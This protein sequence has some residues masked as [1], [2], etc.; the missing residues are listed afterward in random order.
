MPPVF[1]GYFD[2]LNKLNKIGKEY[3]V[4]W[5]YPNH[6]DIWWFYQWINGVFSCGLCSCFA[7]DFSTSSPSSSYAS[8][9]FPCLYPCPCCLSFFS[10]DPYPS[11]CSSFWSC[12]RFLN[13]LPSLFSSSFLRFR[14]SFRIQRNRQ[15]HLMISFAISSHFC[16][17]YSGLTP[18]LVVSAL[19]FLSTFPSLFL[20]ISLFLSPD[21]F[22]FPWNFLSNHLCRVS[23]HLG[24]DHGLYPY[25]FPDPDWTLSSL[26]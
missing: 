7:C 19:I 21:L 1:S 16:L 9:S 4:E 26:P 8:T 18:S 22:I 6:L 15:S 12:H 5:T 25:L 17:F 14:W 10:H 24:H 11:S 2:I 13:V 3:K 20:F 23:S